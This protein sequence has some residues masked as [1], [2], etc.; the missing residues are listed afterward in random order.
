MDEINADWESRIKKFSI[1]TLL[2]PSMARSTP[3]DFVTNFEGYSEN[4]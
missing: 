4:D 2:A 1:K 3:A